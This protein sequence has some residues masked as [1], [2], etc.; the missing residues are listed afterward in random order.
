MCVLASTVQC[1]FRMRILF[2]ICLLKN[3]LTLGLCRTC[4][5]PRDGAQPIRTLYIHKIHKWKF[6]R[7]WKKCFPY[8][9]TSRIWCWCWDFS[10]LLIWSV[11]RIILLHHIQSTHSWHTQLAVQEDV[12]VCIHVGEV[13]VR[14]RV[15]LVRHGSLSAL[16]SCCCG[17]MW[18]AFSRKNFNWRLCIWALRVRKTWMPVFKCLGAYELL[19]VLVSLWPYCADW[20]KSISCWDSCC[21]CLIP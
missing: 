7:I 4:R 3:I 5:G 1:G 2:S 20:F 12:C 6:I 11:E 9:T 21:M 17:W 18:K 8:V 13:K 10:F 14:Q 15:L 16:P 19:N